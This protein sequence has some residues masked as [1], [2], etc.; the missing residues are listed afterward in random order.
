MLSPHVG[1]PNIS[2]AQSG[3]C[4][5]CCRCGFFF[6]HHASVFS[7]RFLRPRLSCLFRPFSR[8]GQPE[9][10]SGGQTEDLPGSLHTPQIRQVRSGESSALVTDPAL[11]SA[12]LNSI[13]EGWQ[14][15]FFFSLL[16]PFFFFISDFTFLPLDLIRDVSFCSFLGLFAIPLVELLS[17][18]S[19]PRKQKVFHLNFSTPLCNLSAIHSWNRGHRA[20]FPFR[21]LDWT[22]WWAESCIFGPHISLQSGARWNNC[23]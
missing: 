8:F 13:I 1:F 20:A 3:V 7:S 16:K 19:C 21:F 23:G 12:I 9:V 15:F 5:F 6:L 4:G 10:P 18:T 22:W 17:S 11:P 2:K 14:T